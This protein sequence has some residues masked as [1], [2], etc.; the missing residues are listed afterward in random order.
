[1]YSFEAKICWTEP[2]RGVKCP[3]P[4][5]SLHTTLYAK[6]HCVLAYNKSPCRRQTVWVPKIHR[7]Y[8]VTTTWRNVFLIPETFMLVFEWYICAYVIYGRIKKQSC[9]S[10]GGFSKFDEGGRYFFFFFFFASERSRS[11]LLS[12]RC[13]LII[14]LL[15][16]MLNV[17][18]TFDVM[19]TRCQKMMRFGY[20]AWISAC[21]MMFVSQW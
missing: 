5:L 16:F 18:H 21:H 1:M 12:C 10:S 17:I 9:F 13:W 6:T 7:F 20:S 14:Q 11:T 8:N 2:L 4:W 15:S 19:W 3:H